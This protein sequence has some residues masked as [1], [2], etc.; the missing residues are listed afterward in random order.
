MW[1]LP[2]KSINRTVGV[3]PTLAKKAK[4]FVVSFST[5]VALIIIISKNAKIRVTLCENAAGHFT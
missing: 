1:P 3:P 2:V 4:R 5:V